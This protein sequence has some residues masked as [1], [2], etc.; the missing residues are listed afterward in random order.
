ML[1]Q[2]SDDLCDNHYY[3]PRIMR[4][5]I[6]NNYQLYV[7]G[8]ATNT[9][10]L[11]DLAIHDRYETRDQ[12][13]PSVNYSG[14][15]LIISTQA[16][17]QDFSEPPLNAYIT[18]MGM[19]MRRGVEAV[20]LLYGGAFGTVNRLLER[21]WLWKK[22]QFYTVKSSP[23]PAHTLLLD[24]LNRTSEQNTNESRSSTYY[25]GGLLS[26]YVMANDRSYRVPTTC[27]LFVLHWQSTLLNQFERE[28]Y[29]MFF[30]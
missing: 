9:I 28:S 14:P 21:F 10:A 2:V 19:T 24:V 29:E 15:P 16:V 20:A 7:G 27:S 25:A 8:V 5:A 17:A 30:I 18:R 3:Y 12:Y 13:P 22:L 6:N 11:I 26:A 1:Q 23:P 4:E